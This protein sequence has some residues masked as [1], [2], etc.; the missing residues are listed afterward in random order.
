[1]AIDTRGYYRDWVRKKT[2][3]VE[4]A[5]F[6]VSHADVERQKF[7]SAWHRNFLVAGAILGF[8]VL[9]TLVKRYFR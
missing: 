3:F 4:R 5:L 8:V 2:G 9:A 1:M 7:R 6:R